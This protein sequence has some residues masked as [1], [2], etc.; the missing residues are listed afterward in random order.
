VDM[1]ANLP[2]RVWVDFLGLLF[3]V[4]GL[5]FCGFVVGLGLWLVFGFVLVFGVGVAG[6][7]SG[8]YYYVPIRHRLVRLDCDVLDRDSFDYFV[9]RA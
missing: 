5:L 2:G 3:V 4:W 7:G 9:Y 1:Y 6:V 8:A